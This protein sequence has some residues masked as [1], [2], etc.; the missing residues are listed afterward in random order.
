MG[1]FLH[2]CSTPDKVVKVLSRIGITVS[3]TTIRRAIKSL[4][5]QSYLDIEKLGRTLL[6]SY[7]YDNFDVLLQT[8]IATV[9]GRD[10]E[11]G[12]L[13]LTSGTL[14]RLEHGV[15]LQDLKCSSLLWNRSELNLHATNP[16]PFDPQATM[17]HLCR[18]HLEPEINEP[19]LLRRQGQY[20]SWM[21]LQTLI[22]YGPNIFARYAQHLPHP[23]P[24]E[25]IPP[26]K[27]HQVPLRAM[28][29]NL[30]RPQ[31]P[32]ILRQYTIC[33][34]RRVLATLMT[35]AC[36]RVNPSSI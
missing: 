35:P 19:G 14:L 22:K 18:L 21:F 23:Q 2:A 8:L 26:T 12:L 17:E 32:G 6:T 33:T 16:I 27:L 10:S 31:S 9:D 20:R 4:S 30:T 24:V 28:D 29:I 13:H 25:V 34:L 3:L 7:A 11:R 15:T 5:T 1:V 36:T